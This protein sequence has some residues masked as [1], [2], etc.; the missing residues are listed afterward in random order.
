MGAS[1]NSD[2][3]GQAWSAPPD[4]GLV[5]HASS[6]DDPPTWLGLHPHFLIVHDYLKH[7]SP[8]GLLPGRQHFEP[9]DIRRVL[10]SIMLIDVV[11]AA[12]AMRFQLVVVGT[13][14]VAAL[15]KEVTGQYI[16][17]AFGQEP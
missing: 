17:E 13:E 7:R 2:T 5:L 9:L 15:G 6:P 1:R 14:V 11:R 8:P 3:A 16:D 4:R 12:A 10:P